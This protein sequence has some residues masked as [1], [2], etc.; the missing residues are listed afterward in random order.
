M[1]NSAPFQIDWK[2]L[3]LFNFYRL[4]L[5]SIF[6]ALFI[7]D[8]L[9]NVIGKYLPRLF[10]VVSSIYFVS[11]LLSVF[12]IYYQR[13]HF[14]VQVFG[15]AIVDI[16]IISLL[17]HASGGLSSGLGALLVVAVA[18]YSLLTEGRTA[19]L[20]AAIATVAVLL[21][22]MVADFYNAFDVPNYTQAAI[23]GVGFFATAFLVHALAQRVRKSEYSAYQHKLYSEQLAQLN[24]QIVAHIRSG[25][26]VLDSANQIRLINESAQ[27]LLE[28]GE[29]Q[30]TNMPLLQIMPDLAEQFV[31]W[32]RGQSSATY[33]FKIKHSETEVIATFSRL[34]QAGDIKALIFIEDAALTMQRAENIKLPALGRLT[35]SIAHEIRNPLAAISQAGQL[36]V[37]CPDLSERYLPF[38]EMVVE[39]ST[40]INRIINSILQISRQ[41]EADRR[42]IELNQWIETFY[43]ELC[44]HYALAK[45]HIELHLAKQSLIIE[46][47]PIQLHQVMWNLCENALRYSQGEKRLLIST[48]SNVQNKRPYVEIEDFGQGIAK[49]DEHKIFE[50]F[51]TTRTE[52]IGLGLYI[53]RDLCVANQASLK[54]VK[55]SPKGCCFKIN[56]SSIG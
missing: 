7:T 14:N 25:I 33:W 17:M 42:T 38:A 37:E 20:S 51:F 53:S 41:R 3:Q 54:L 21:E 22:T 27:Q 2:P 31:R 34:H 35:A 30:T 44:G 36:L 6:I 50:P 1:S 26:I 24:Q 49:E 8:S 12:T 19:F 32:E 16:I 23:L 18:G 28:I 5:A 48:G 10:L 40:R 29:L 43:V 52:G 13:P 39:Q 56:F 55:N 47:D 15:Q 9:P 46:F 11:A 45:Q 4:L